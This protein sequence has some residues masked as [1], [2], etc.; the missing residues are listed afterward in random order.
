M[1]NMPNVTMKSGSFSLA[2]I[3]PFTR[4]Q[5]TPNS[6]P[7]AIPRNKLCVSMP[8]VIMLV[9]PTI[10][11]TERSIPRVMMTKVMPT[12]IIVLIEDCSRMS[13]RFAGW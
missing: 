2:I 12:A 11:P 7:A 6:I 9:R 10:E 8:A 13:R 1:L 5:V 3:K 4:P